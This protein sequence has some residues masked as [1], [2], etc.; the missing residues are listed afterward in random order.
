MKQAITWTADL[1]RP[2][3]FAYPRSQQANT[4]RPF[5]AYLALGAAHAPL[6][7]PKEYIEKYRG[8]FNQGWN[9]VRR[10]TFERQ[11]RMGIL[12]ADAVLPPPNPGIRAWDDLSED[13]Q[14]V[15]CRLQECFAGFLDHTDHHLG[16]LLDAL[17][18]ME[19]T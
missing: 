12:S 16:R 9:E 5:F 1:V 8:R 3:N 14:K 13:A 19:L 11:K 4:G 7:A 15:Y 18:E 6:H 10:E 2:N 17:Y